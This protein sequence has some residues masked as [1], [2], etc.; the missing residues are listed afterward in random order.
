MLL[1]LLLLIPAP[2]MACGVISIAGLAQVTAD[3]LSAKGPRALIALPLLRTAFGGSFIE[4]PSSTARF[5]LDVTGGALLVWP[6][7]E[8]LGPEFGGTP[9]LM[10]EAGYSMRLNPDGL[11]RHLFT[12]GAGA[13]WGALFV[14]GFTYA[15]RFVVGRLGDQTLVG[16]RH[17][18]AAHLVMGSIYVELGHQLLRA[19]GTGPVEHEM[20]FSMGLNPASVLFHHLRKKSS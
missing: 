3:A 4:L 17:G 9:F 8:F 19:A 10:P 16:F 20:I 18:L 6:R 13:G 15:P 7:D 1:S 2:A 14:A 12:L 11:H 5:T